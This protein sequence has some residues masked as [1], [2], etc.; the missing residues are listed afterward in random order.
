MIETA[1]LNQGWDDGTDW[2]ALAQKAVARAI[3]L[4]P[5]AGLA[6]ADVEIE[7]AV[8]LT[9]D[10]EVHILN[11]DYRGKD[12]PTN[13][14]SFPMFDPDEIDGL[15]EGPFPEAMLG[16]IVLAKETCAREAEE[17]GIPFST[18][19]THLMV[20]GVLHLIGFDHIS[21]ADAEDM[22][23]LERLIMADLGHDDPYGD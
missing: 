8:R 3:A 14:L 5:H 23:G 17:K 11:R 7:I 20:H 21:D 15:A 10:A 12:K 16:D 2:E 4:S 22:E 1:V 13:V 19:A 9:A 6:S 18:H